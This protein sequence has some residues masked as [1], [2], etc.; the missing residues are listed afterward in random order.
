MIT[1]YDL[2]L[3]FGQGKAAQVWDAHL[4]PAKAGNASFSNFSGA[5][6]S[7]GGGAGVNLNGSCTNCANGSAIDGTARG[8]FTGNDA[9][10]L[11]TNYQLKNG[12]DGAVVNGAAA[13]KR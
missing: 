5:G 4:D 3:Q 7:A 1:A 2:N 9:R 8:L 11:M 13:L 6:Q 10:G 12:A